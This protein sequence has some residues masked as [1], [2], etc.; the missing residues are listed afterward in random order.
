LPGT[1]LTPREHQGYEYG[2]CAHARSVALISA[3]FANTSDRISNR[4]RGL[5]ISASAY[6]LWGC[7]WR[8]GRD[9]AGSGV[10]V[11]LSQQRR[12]SRQLTAIRSEICRL[13]KSTQ[14][15]AAQHL[16]PS[17]FSCGRSRD[18]SAGFRSRPS[19]RRAKPLKQLLAIMLV[20]TVA[21]VLTLGRGVPPRCAVA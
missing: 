15:E 19:L 12:R 7:G 10:A 9:R 2:D 16:G 5:S 3:A 1:G 21:I 18:I 13:R 4:I 17:V 8:V 20:L 6:S 11:P 14:Y